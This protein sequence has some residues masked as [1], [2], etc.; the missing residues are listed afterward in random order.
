MGADR[1]TTI[2]GAVLAAGGGTRFRAGGAAGHKLLAA[3]RG[4]PVV[5]WAIEAAAGAGFDQLYLVTGAADLGDVLSD[6]LGG[7]LGENA[8]A[9]VTVVHNPAWS[10]GQATSLAA[11][12]DMAD[13]DGHDAL[14]VGLG[15]QP[16]VPSDAWQAVATAPGLIVTATF[17]GER[18]P[19]TKLD[20]AVW[21]KLARHGDQGARALMRELPG[22][23]SEIPCRGNPVDI[24]TMEDLRRWS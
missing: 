18:R 5:A 10:E 22:S 23:V 14:V 19:P 17:D 15:D 13:A 24:D 4:R 8:S 7:G 2:A 3:F 6:V 16:L 21:P 20:R 1:A 11:A 12:V 9:N